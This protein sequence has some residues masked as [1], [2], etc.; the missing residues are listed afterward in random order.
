[1]SDGLSTFFFFGFTITEYCCS[2]KQLNTSHIVVNLYAPYFF[3]TKTNWHIKHGARNF[4][5][6]LD[7]ARKCLKPDEFEVVKSPFQNG[8]NHFS[9]K[10]TSE[11]VSKRMKGNGT[12]TR[13]IIVKL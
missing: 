7:L 2:G 13:A 1:M 12:H 8:V 10:N 11:V 5:Y 3:R 9:T 4:F 6:A